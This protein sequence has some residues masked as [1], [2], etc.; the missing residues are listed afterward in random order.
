MKAKRIILVE[1]DADDIELF[2]T[3]LSN[4][5]DIELLPPVHNGIELINYLQNIVDGNQMPDLIVLDQNMPLMSGKETLKVLKSS[6]LLSKIPAVIYS[7]YTDSSLIVDCKKLGADMVAVK[8]I[9]E[10]GY[11]KMM[12]DFLLMLAK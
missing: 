10:E 12:D 11:V 4:R 9:D 7:T 2:E 8:P 5:E 3:F 1:D 6:E